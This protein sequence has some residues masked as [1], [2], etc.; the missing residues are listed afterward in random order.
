MTFKNHP[1][2]EYLSSLLSN[3][4]TTF[5][6][7]TFAEPKEF[8]KS[9]LLEGQGGAGKTW[10][11]LNDPGLINPVYIVHSWDKATEEQESFIKTKPSKS[12]PLRNV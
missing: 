7:W 2:T 1:T 3:D 10:S 5:D 11:L 8:Y 9:E 12:Y 6:N 4:N